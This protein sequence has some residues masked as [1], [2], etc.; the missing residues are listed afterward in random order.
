[1]SN[2]KVLIVGAGPTGLTAAILLTQANHEVRIIDKLD[3]P[4]D[5]SKAMAVN[6]RSLQILEESGITD[7]LIS[8]GK[9]LRY[10]QLG[11]P[12][13]PLAALD[14]S[15]S[16]H[17]FSHMV[18]LPQSETERLLTSKLN[19]LEV[20]IERGTELTD[21]DQTEESVE[22]TLETNGVSEKF[23]CDYL[24]GANGASSKRHT[25][26]SPSRNGT[27]VCP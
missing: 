20:E 6:P 1:M 5:Y 2:K 4:V 19:S 15:K 12:G 14:L 7:T 26:T 11:L 21:F 13:K 22:C 18:G 27:V 17:R 8:Q 10:I 16:E 23:S 24:V 3:Q 25:T 9:K